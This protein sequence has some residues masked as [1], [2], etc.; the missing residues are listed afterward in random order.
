M[1]LMDLK[2]QIKNEMSLLS[3]RPRDYL[4]IQFLKF[5][6]LCESE[7]LMPL[8]EIKEIMKSYAV[9]G[10]KPDPPS[11]QFFRGLI[12]IIDFFKSELFYTFKKHFYYFYEILIK[13]SLIQSFFV[14]LIATIFMMYV[15]R[16]IFFEGYFFVFI[17]C[18]IFNVVF[19]CLF[20]YSDR[21][22]I[23]D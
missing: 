4:I 23:N 7:K 3:D 5:V 2:R 16:R 22:E 18:V 10:V 17:G 12:F 8:S 19:R 15:L 6:D 21:E 13:P 11:I 20:G 1:G 9:D 14:G